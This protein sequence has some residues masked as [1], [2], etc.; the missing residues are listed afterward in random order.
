MTP[1]L[2]YVHIRGS[3]TALQ[4]RERIYDVSCYDS[5]LRERLNDAR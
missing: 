5:T 4:L 1:S 3:A 2:T